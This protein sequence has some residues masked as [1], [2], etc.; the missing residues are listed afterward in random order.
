MGTLELQFLVRGRDTGLG[1][2]GD[3]TPKDAES[4]SAMNHQEYLDFLTVWGEQFASVMIEDAGAKDV[5]PQDAYEVFVEAFPEEPTPTR[6]A[7]LS[8]QELEMLRAKCEKVLEHRPI[9]VASL[10]KAIS[11]TLCAWSPAG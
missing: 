6:L 1:R 3:A 11:L 7:A 8:E 2:R 4:Q 5:T 10:R 9:P